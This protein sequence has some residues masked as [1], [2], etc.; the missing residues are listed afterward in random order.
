MIPFVD[1]IITMGAYSF[2]WGAP[3]EGQ[4]GI[5]NLAYTLPVSWGP[6]DSLT[7]YSDNTVIEPR[8]SRFDTIWQNVVGCLVAAGP[9]YTYVDIISGENMIFMGGNM[10]GEANFGSEGRNTRL[11]V[12]F[13]YYF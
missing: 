7:F 12:N 6:I 4:I 11:N 5:A 13:G 2:S 1:D 3:A 10:V 8:E 9:F